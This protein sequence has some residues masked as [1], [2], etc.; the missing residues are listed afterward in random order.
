MPI[1]A[2]SLAISATALFLGTLSASAQEAVNCS[3][4]NSVASYAPGAGLD[5]TFINS[6][7]S[8]RT[9]MWQ[10][11]SGAP[12]YLMDLDVGERA[13]YMVA[14]GDVFAMVDGPGN[15]V[16]MF[17]VTAGQSQYVMRAIA[18]GEGGD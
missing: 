6:S 8:R 1:H 17:R 16:E 15:C 4:F 13:G 9:V 2:K 5:L 3:Q 11:T 18:T 12:V 7:D 10:N 14:P